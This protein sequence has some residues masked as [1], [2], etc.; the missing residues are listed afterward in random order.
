M[1][2][3]DSER[4]YTLESRLPHRVQLCSGPGRSHRCCAVVPVP[5]VP[6]LA[7]SI[8]AEIDV[9]LDSHLRRFVG[10]ALRLHGIAGTLRRASGHALGVP[11]CKNEISSGTAPTRR[12]SAAPSSPAPSPPSGARLRSAGED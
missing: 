12:E 10:V 7:A 9:D 4:G 1:T 2:G 6:R 8:D 11:P 3:A 5:S